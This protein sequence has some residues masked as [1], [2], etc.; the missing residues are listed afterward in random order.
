MITLRAGDALAEVV[1]ERG[2]ICSRLRLGGSELLY[3]DPAGRS[4]NSLDARPATPRPD[5][6]QVAG[7]RL[8]E[9]LAVDHDRHPGHEERLYGIPKRFEDL[10]AETLVARSPARAI[11]K[12]THGEHCHR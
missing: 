6:D 4:E 11:D 8:A 1:P 9:P 5:D 12:L 2:A 3:L 7:A 10:S